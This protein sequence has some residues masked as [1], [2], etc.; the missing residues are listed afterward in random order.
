MPPLILFNNHSSSSGQKNTT[1]LLD[2]TQ[3]PGATA[4]SQS[5]IT[6][7]VASQQH[8]QQ[9][10]MISIRE[11][12]QDSASMSAP[13]APMT[14]E[15]G[16]VP[17]GTLWTA[18]YDYE[19][20]GE[21]ELS[22][23]RGQ[24]VCVLSMDSN[25]SGDEGW[26]TGKIGDKVGIFPSNFVTN[27][28]PMLV[29]VPSSIG[30]IQPLEIAYEELD[31][32]EVI[33]VGGFCKVHRGFYGHEEV[34]VKAARQGPDEDIEITRENV[35]QEAKLFWAL[36]HEN[37]VA[38]R[39]VCLKP[40]KLCLVMEYA[41]GGS[42]NRI[43]AGRKIPPHVLVNWAI[44]IA[45]GMN[46]LHNEA[47]LSIIHRDLKSSN[48]LIFEAIDGDNLE[49][50]TLKITDFGLARELYNTTRMSAAGTY[51]WMPPEVIS[52]GTYSKSSDVWS[53]GVLLWE[54]ITGETPY[55]GFDSLS[56]AYGVAVNTLALPIPKTCPE[57]WGKLM[58]SCWE[59]DPHKRPGFMDILMKLEDIARSGFTQTPQ[60]SF[61]TMQDG[62]KKEIAEVL[63]E[64][65]MKEKE[66]RCK[67]A[68][69][70][71]VQLQQREQ[72]KDLQL[73]EQELMA[74]EL[75]LI[76]RELIIAQNTPV[77]R[78]RKGRFKKLKLLKRE[79]AQISLPIDFRH[80]ITTIRDKSRARTDTPPGSPAISGLRIVALPPDGFKGKTWGPS[81][82]H[83]RE[84][85][86]LL[87]SLHS[88]EWKPSSHFSKSAPNLD[89]SRIAFPQQPPGTQ[90][91]IAAT[92]S[93]M[94]AGNTIGYIPQGI[95]ISSTKFQHYTI[96][97]NKNNN[98]T[99]S[100]INISSLSNYSGN[101]LINNNN[102]N[103]LSNNSIRKSKKKSKTSTAASSISPPRR[104]SSNNNGNNNSI[105]LAKSQDVESLRNVA[106]SSAQIPFSYSFINSFGGS[107]SSGGTLF[108]NSV[109]H[110]HQLSISSNNDQI[111]SSGGGGVG[112]SVPMTTYEDDDEI[113][114]PTGCFNLRRMANSQSSS[115][116]TMKISN[117]TPPNGGQKKHSLDSKIP[118]LIQTQRECSSTLAVT[119]IDN[120]TY[121]RVFYKAMQKSLDE[122]FST[123]CDI[124]TISSANRHVWN[125][126]EKASSKS[127]GDLTMYS[128][129]S[130]IQQGPDETE[131]AYRFQRN[132]SGSQ[133]PRHYFFRQ[134]SNSLGDKVA[135][136][137]KSSSSSSRSSSRSEVDQF[138]ESFN[139][140]SCQQGTQVLNS[141]YSSSADVSRKSSVVTFQCT[142]TDELNSSF[143]Q[144][145]DCFYKESNNS[146]S[147]T[148]NYSDDADENAD[149]IGAQS[150]NT[151]DFILPNSMMASRKLKDIKPD[152][153]GMKHNS[154]SHLHLNKQGKKKKTVLAGGKLKDFMNFFSFG[155][156]GRNSKKKL[157]Q[158]S[159][160]AAY[161]L[162]KNN[163]ELNGIEGE[164][165]IV[166]NSSKT[167]EDDAE[168]IE[169][170]ET[171]K[172][173]VVI[174]NENN[175]TT[176]D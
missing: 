43:L 128:F 9:P 102:H 109:R 78:K 97:N 127:S 114:K 44:Q 13:G 120:V 151:S 122:I 35:L 143:K 176:Q 57:A 104:G 16:G 121:D 86:H 167:Q 83:Q 26:W 123:P 25:I 107:C 47:P 58:K 137:S 4:D 37:I 32:Q 99:I 30:E 101:N 139:S 33:G 112:S 60:E 168:V 132:G 161:T 19:A 74:R 136:I 163:S 28:D 138:S 77:P 17:D 42:L 147:F 39:G 14:A 170:I 90:S 155:T 126:S 124:S 158:T 7:T 119:N 162:F 142:K 65:R 159:G 116:S 117:Q 87:P 94:I 15:N 157:A 54:L 106:N 152:T 5:D 133:F 6:S 100:N 8:Q 1:A 140:S 148:T 24:I 85:S 45:C 115:T 59:N 91:A 61:H 31:V 153:E 48:V 21:D 165:V 67:E 40:P 53:Y 134:E 55:K 96:A 118:S 10:Q 29:N 73:R 50:K 82:V 51:A 108:G 150:S 52:R 80:T 56:V 111:I 70:R 66:L 169:T 92:T 2:G 18:L 79:P 172:K 149:D 63:Y 110:T 75:E 135:M 129:D 3:E 11:E 146:F 131:S 72:A 113:E 144:D 93:A 12:H 27:E 38:L 145:Q 105:Q 130:A 64:L 41:R 141:E 154:S 160:S 171:F 174:T 69:L 173:E 71:R 88:T 76:G 68:E 36:K 34:A 89:K 166:A 164:E 20:Q 95:P 81:T 175:K 156:L 62:W 46:Y 98:H 22:L 49:N 23:N 103:K 84:R 125:H